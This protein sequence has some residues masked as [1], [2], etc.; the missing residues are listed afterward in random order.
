ML[1]KPTR[2]TESRRPSIS[3]SQHGWEGCSIPATLDNLLAHLPTWRHMRVFRPPETHKGRTLLFT[4]DVLKDASGVPIRPAI[5]MGALLGEGSYGKVYKARRALFRPDVDDPSH[6]ERIVDFHPIVSKQTPVQIT[7]HEKALPADEQELI[8]EEEIQAILYEAALHAL[9]YHT[10]HQH[11]HTSV[12]PALYEVLA[13]SPNR[14][15]TM[16]SD[17]QS[18]AIHMDYVGGETLFNYFTTHL[19]PSTDPVRRQANDMRLLDILIQLC[20][21]LDILQTDLRFNHR[22]LKVNN[23]LIRHHT[24]PWSRLISMVDATNAWLCSHDVVLIDFGFSCIA[25]GDADVSS[26]VQAGSWFKPHHDCM[27]RGRDLALFLYCLESCFPLKDRITDTL[28]DILYTSMMAY[29]DADPATGIPLWNGVDGSGAPIVGGG[30]G[31]G[32]SSSHKLSFD[33]GIY[34]FLRSSDVDVPGCAP[35]ALAARL[36]TFWQSVVVLST[37]S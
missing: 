33:A 24:R 11:G 25:C 29:K 15:P 20:V 14:H 26:L 5:E 34:K 18:I 22:D 12:V 4:W 3:L 1:S 8:Y 36:Y 13:F 9:V 31:S 37:S 19:T 32:S 27:K 10:L 16:P 28:Y 23:V 17:I 21:Y 7:D 30:G 2:G 6:H 35:S